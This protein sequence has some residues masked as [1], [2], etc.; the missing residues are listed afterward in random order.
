MSSLAPVPCSG[1]HGFVS[2]SL[3]RYPFANIP[4][5]VCE[6]GSACFGGSQKLHCFE[7][8]ETNVFEI[9]SH[10]SSFLFKRRPERIHVLPYKPP[11]YSQDH[12]LLC[13][14]KS[15]DSAAHWLTLSLS[16]FLHFRPARGLCHSSQKLD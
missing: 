7:V 4:R 3:S 11:A 16:A 14:N 5:A 2:V 12:T 13:R 10:R 6:F 9:D 8:R 1:L 15:V